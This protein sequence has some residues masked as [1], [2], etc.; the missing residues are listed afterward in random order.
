M[1]IFVDTN[2]LLDVLLKRE[3][4]YEKSALLWSAVK[5]NIVKGYISA[6]STTNIFYIAKKT[7]GNEKAMELVKIILNTFKISKVDFSILNSAEKF[8]MK[9]YED[10]VQYACAV[11]SDCEY[12][13][14]RNKKDF[15]INGIKIIDSEEFYDLIIK[16]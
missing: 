4:F 3:P 13:I 7:L 8:K 5:N 10:A 9:D 11:E 12:M 2:I 16:D 1:K 14:T 6:V 15:R